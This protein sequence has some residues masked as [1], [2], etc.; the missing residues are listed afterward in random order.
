M[1]LCW[2][3]LQARAACLV[4][5]L[6]LAASGLAQ[7]QERQSAS[8]SAAQEAAV[9]KPALVVSVGG[10]NKLIPD[11]MYLMRAVGQ[12]AAGGIASMMTNQFTAGVD[13]DRPMGVA[14]TVLPDGPPETV[15]MLPV[16]DVQKFL[17][18]LTQSNAVTSDEIGENRY[19]LTVGLETQMYAVYKNDWLFVTQFEE[20]LDNISLDP[21]TLLPKLAE[22]YDIA[23]NVYVQEIPQAQRDE[24][25]QNLDQGFEMAMAQGS[26]GQSSEEAAAAR[27]QGEQTIAQLKEIFE[28]TDQLL[29]GLNVDANAKAVYFDVGTKFVAGSR[30][31]K[32]AA[33]NK[34]LTSSFASFVQASDPIQIKFRSKL[35]PAD[36]EASEASFAMQREQLEGLVKTVEDPEAAAA[37]REGATMFLDAIQRTMKSGEIDGA[38]AMNFDNGVNMVAGGTV[39]DAAALEKDFTGFLEKH[40][41]D[42]AAP[43]LVGSPSNYKGMR[44]YNGTWELPED[45]DLAELRDAIGD[46][47]PFVVAFGEDEAALAIGVNSDP[48]IKAALD[49]MQNNKQ[50][51]A[52]PAEVRVELLPILEYA[53]TLVA[54]SDES[55]QLQAAI[56]KASE[57]AANDALQISSRVVENGAVVRIAI[58][59]GILQ[60]IGAAAVGAAPPR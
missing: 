7:A 52:Y 6:C 17:T 39:V 16:S 4:G 19:E 41:S 29:V 57:F 24:L 55:R 35:S 44:L 8:P 46:A 1:K 12:P 47:L 13:R 33:L 15:V 11:V 42:P 31:A 30:L 50:V 37:L 59:E 53:Q 38:Y 40:S 14:V 48:N 49:R 10:L 5:L 34:D 51:P 43:K 26:E 20:Q 27:A 18:G 28:S 9:Q 21:G 60:T 45:E 22:R 58:E 54:E 36:I 32:N 25:L 3:A 2:S 23:V 56:A